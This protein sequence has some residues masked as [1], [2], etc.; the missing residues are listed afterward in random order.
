MQGGNAY[1]FGGRVDEVAVYDQALTPA[2]V[3]NDY[4]AAQ[5]GLVPPP[6]PQP[7]AA[8]SGLSA[9]V[10]TPTTIALSWT[11]AATNESQYV[12]ERSGSPAFGAVTSI[13][14]PANT[15]SYSDTVP[16]GDV[17]YYRVRAMNSAGWL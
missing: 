10:T 2:Q 7:P 11:D 9:E 3:V 12:V 17:Y 6:L 15:T 4:V 14:L 1:Y 16:A 8:P 5:N 13:P